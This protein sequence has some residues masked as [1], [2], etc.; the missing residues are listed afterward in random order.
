MNKSLLACKLILFAATSAAG[1]NERPLKVFVLAGTSNMLG[2]V[3]KIDKLPEDF[4]QP[5][6]DVLVYQKGEWTPL[7]AGKNL[8]G[9]EA[10]FGRAISTHLG[11]PIGIVWISVASAGDKSPAAGINNIVKQAKGKGRP[12]VIAGMLLDVSFRD[13]I[14]EETAKAYGENL[15]RWIESTRKEIG[16]VNLPIVMNRAIPPV[17]GTPFLELVRKA[18]DSAKL[19]HFRVFNCDDV[20]R[21][22]DKVHFNTEGRLEMG[23]RFAAAMM[24]LMPMPNQNKTASTWKSVTT[25]E[26][27]WVQ[28]G[29][30]KVLFYQRKSKSKDGKH[31]RANYVHP[32]LDLDGEPLT[33]DFPADHLH[34][35]GIFWAWHQVTIGGKSVGDPWALKDCGWDI[36]DVKTESED[37]AMTLRT[38]VHWLS[39]LWRDEKGAQKPLMREQAVVRVHRAEKERRVVDF[40]IALTALQA[41]TRIGGASPKPG[42]GGFSPRLRLPKDV[43]FLG[44]KGD[45]KPLAEAVAPAAWIDVAG[46]LTKD[47]IS[48][49]AML[50]HPSSPGF[51]QPWILRKSGSMQ[52]PVYPGATPVLVSMETPLALRYRLVIH[53]G[54]APVEQIER[55]QREYTEFNFR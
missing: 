26:G 45:V 52:N 24:E 20:S 6:K 47:R 22:G 41:E 50:T 11:E 35:R 32:L 18:Q 17:P 53:R 30:A 15:M 2:A 46:T 25:D 1:E 40:E 9:N 38:T 37:G 34:H 29:E 19:S 12:I 48:G 4:R 36:R 23:K 33:E 51:P 42:Y 28:E 14:K 31:P 43:R 5:L 10:T 49:V 27:V 7:E 44:P 13:G 39:P 3:A 21:G 8:V 55:W 16:N 54:A